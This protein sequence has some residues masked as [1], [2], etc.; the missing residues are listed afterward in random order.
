MQ[1]HMDYSWSWITAAFLVLSGISTWVIRS[2]LRTEHPEAFGTLGLSTG[3]W[4]AGTNWEL[5][6]WLF[7]FR[8]FSL[9]DKT[10]TFLCLATKFIWL[11]TVYLIFAEP[12]YFE[13]STTS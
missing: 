11:A 7:T 5:T 13:L 10:L 3:G 8:Y 4:Q 12:L 9:S 2:R 6:K 1:S